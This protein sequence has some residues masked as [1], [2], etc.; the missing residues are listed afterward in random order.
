M[1]VFNVI[2]KIEFYFG[3]FLGATELPKDLKKIWDSI[4]IFLQL[5]IEIIIFLPQGYYIGPPSSKISKT[6]SCF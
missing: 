1:D 4:T 3:C 6:H 2:K 5:Q